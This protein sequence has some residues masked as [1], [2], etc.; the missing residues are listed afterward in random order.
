MYIY[1]YNYNVW[2]DQKMGQNKTKSWAG[3]PKATR[4]GDNFIRVTN[5]H[6]RRLTTSNISAQLN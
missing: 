3:R 4:A 1:A 6:N 5:L 2:R